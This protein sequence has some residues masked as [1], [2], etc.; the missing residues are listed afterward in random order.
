MTQMYEKRNPTAT[1]R[2]EQ[3]SH[4]YMQPTPFIP[5]LETL[6]TYCRYGG[7][8]DCINFRRVSISKYTDF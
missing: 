4:V 5:G 3:L 1:N 6:H 2:D 8:L 7:S